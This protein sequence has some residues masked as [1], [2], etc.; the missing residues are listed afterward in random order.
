MAGTSVPQTHA[1]A[2]FY[3]MHLGMI[4]VLPST[5]LGMLVA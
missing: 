2:T 4:V 5:R 3:E 1:P